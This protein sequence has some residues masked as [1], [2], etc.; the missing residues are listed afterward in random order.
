MR[1]IRGHL[2]WQTIDLRLRAMR[3]IWVTITRPDG[4]PDAVPVWFWWSLETAPAIVV[5][6]G[7]GV[8]PIIAEGT[9]ALVTETDEL[10]RVKAAYNEKYIDPATGHPAAVDPTV[11]VVFRVGVKRVQVGAY[12]NAATQTDWQFD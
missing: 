10:E 12:A 5:H 1:P 8:D 9:A 11:D 7:D 2:D 4:R 6:N 3:E